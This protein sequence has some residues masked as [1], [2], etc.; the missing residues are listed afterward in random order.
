VAPCADA[1]YADAIRIDAPLRGV[2]ADEL[3]C[4]GNIAPAFHHIVFRAAAVTDGEH[5]IASVYEWYKHGFVCLLH[6]LAAHPAATDHVGHR[7]TIGI[8]IG[9]IHIH[10]QC[11]AIFVAI[12]DIANRFR[13]RDIAEEAE[14][15][16]EQKLN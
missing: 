10:H 9:L 7:G 4:G 14:A 13:L 5:G 12:R 1:G 16:D 8:A 15:D 11:H 2:V 3:E 6:A